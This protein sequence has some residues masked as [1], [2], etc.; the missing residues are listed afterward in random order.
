MIWNI[1]SI[2]ASD[3]PAK[4]ELIIDVLLASA[5]IPGAFPPMLVEVEAN[6][7]LYDEMH[8]DGGTVSQ[9]FVYPSAVDMKT[10]LE[11]ME[12]TEP[13]E[14]Y[15][16]RNAKLLP[17]WKPVE[18]SIFEIAGTSISSLIRTQGLGDLYQIYFLTQR[19]GGEYFLAYIPDDFDLES[20]E[21]FDPAYM[22][23]LYDL[24]YE[25]A[26]AGFPWR[27]LPPGA[28]EVELDLQ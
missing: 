25:M 19:D 1:T 16:I 11:R 13:P 3:Y 7:K 17:K 22:K 20:D 2:A 5:S 4:R 12:V 21:L 14:I 15:V 28:E 24:G 23:A 27:R 26:E 18:A 10:I 9:V 8:V 6:G